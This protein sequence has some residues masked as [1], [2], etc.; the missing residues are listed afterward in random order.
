M[1]IIVE[2]DISAQKYMNAQDVIRRNRRETHTHTHTHT[3]VLSLS[4]IVVR[5]FALMN[6]AEDSW[7]SPA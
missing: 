3:H 2:E 4:L 1:C 7:E 6:P 5:L